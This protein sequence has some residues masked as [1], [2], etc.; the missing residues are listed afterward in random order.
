MIQ[1][2][3]LVKSVASSRATPAS[4]FASVAKSKAR[5]T[6]KWPTSSPTSISPCAIVSARATVLTRAADA[7]L[8]AVPSAAP[9]PLD[10]ISISQYASDSV[11]YALNLAKI[12]ETYEVH[13]WMLLLGILKYEKCKAC[14]IL[15]SL[16]LVDLYS[17]WH[18]VMWALH[19]V[20]GFEAKSY[21]PNIGFS[22]RAFRIMKG[23][24]NFAAWGGRTK[25]QTEDLVMALA[26]GEVLEGLFPDLK[27]EF[28]SVRKAA[29]EAGCHYLLPDDDEEEGSGGSKD[30]FL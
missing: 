27:M 17:A 25:V 10:D 16:G 7:A 22:S 30:N 24:T 20:D 13:S 14:T 29:A 23:A 15:K 2:C 8:E 26:A 1:S 6:C 18:E 3:S 11:Q 9:S 19:S 12:S 4:A 5:V 28:E 21:Q